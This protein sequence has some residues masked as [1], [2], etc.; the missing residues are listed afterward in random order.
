M[1]AAAVL[2]SAQ[3]PWSPLCG[4]GI[5]SNVLVH[6]LWEN[7]M[8]PLRGVIRGKTIELDR[9]P[10][11]PDGQAVAVTVHPLLPLGEGIKRSAGGWGDDP[12]GLDA[13]LKEMRRSRKQDRP[14]PT[15]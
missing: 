6:C 8:P 13:W 9:E 1:L 2:L 4:Y 10:G 15:R 7:A 3:T 14:G 5:M 11:L 12:E